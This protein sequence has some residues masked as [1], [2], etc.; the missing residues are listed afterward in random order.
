M[1]GALQ[2]GLVTPNTEFDIPPILHF[3]DRQISDAEAHG[4]ETLNVANILKF[5]ATSAPI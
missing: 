3:A 4:Y 1:A 5:R 2:D